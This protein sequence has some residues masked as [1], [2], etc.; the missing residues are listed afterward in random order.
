MVI[1]SD[2]VYR[3]TGAINSFPLRRRC[4]VT[5]AITSTTAAPAAAGSKTT[6]YEQQACNDLLDLF[7]PPSSSFI[8][9]ANTKPFVWFPKLKKKKIKN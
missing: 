5:P 8:I 6:P 9:T 1:D 3:P 7:V 2:T 4:G